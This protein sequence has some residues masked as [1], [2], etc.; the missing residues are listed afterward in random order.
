MEQVHDLGNASSADVP[1][2][3]Q[4][5]VVANRAFLDET[6]EAQRLFEG[7]TKRIA[8]SSLLASWTT[9]ERWQAGASCL[10]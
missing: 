10:K 3:S 5:G 6:L 2:K 7:G 8:Y 1:K 4:L 9:T